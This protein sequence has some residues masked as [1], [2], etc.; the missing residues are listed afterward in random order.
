MTAADALVATVVE[1]RRILRGIMGA[2]AYERYLEFHATHHDGHP[3]M[4][5]REFWRDRDDRRDR[6]PEG[7]CC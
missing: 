2:D 4:T 5:E 3:P 7:R 6:N 1:A